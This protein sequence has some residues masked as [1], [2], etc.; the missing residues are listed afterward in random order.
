MVLKKETFRTSWMHHNL[1]YTLSK[2]WI[3]V[4]HEH[5]TDTA[6]LCCPCTATVVGAIESKGIRG[7]AGKIG[8]GAAA[9]GIIGALLGGAKGAVAGVLIGGGGTLAATEGKDV[10]LP[11]GSMLRVRLDTPLDI[12]RQSFN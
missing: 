2:L 5:H 6:I 9:G 1:V 4:G 7:E 3:S 12:T 11:A 8:V 10:E